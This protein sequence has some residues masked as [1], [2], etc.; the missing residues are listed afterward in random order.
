MWPHYVARNICLATLKIRGLQL[1][2][3]KSSLWF[4]L[5]HFFSFYKTWTCLK[6][7]DQIEER[8]FR[9][10]ASIP[11][12]C[13]NHHPKYLPG[14]ETQGSW[15]IVITAAESLG[16]WRP[17][18]ASL[19]LPW[20]NLSTWWLSHWGWEAK[21]EKISF[22]V[23]LFYGRLDRSVMIMWDQFTSPFKQSGVELLL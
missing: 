16:V 15:S 6:F 1:R 14:G 9:L 11:T 2:D 13:Q 22:R 17:G 23:F 4:V 21:L 20:S 12:K 7:V 8:R 3:R 5:N 19:H 10:E 18:G